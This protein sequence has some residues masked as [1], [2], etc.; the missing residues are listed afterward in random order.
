MLLSVLC[1]LALRLKSMKHFLLPP[2]KAG[3]NPESRSL[4]RELDASSTRRSGFGQR[5]KRVK[6]LL[7]K[8]NVV[9]VMDLNTAAAGLLCVRLKRQIRDII[10]KRRICV[11]FDV[12]QLRFRCGSNGRLSLDSEMTLTVSSE[13]TQKDS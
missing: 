3:N 4:R 9:K 8:R 6:S 7:Q 2:P 10:D 13:P 12:A 11:S 1:E 5:R